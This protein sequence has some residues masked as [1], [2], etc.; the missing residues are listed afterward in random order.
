MG[1]RTTKSKIKA[2]SNKAKTFDPINATANISYTA[3]FY[4]TFR[5][6]LII[7]IPLVIIS[8]IILSSLHISATD[9]TSSTDTLSFNIS[10]SCTLSSV[11]DSSHT[12][13]LIN[14]TYTNSIGQTTITTLCND[15]NGYSVY[16]VGYS[17]NE[18]G[19]N[20]LVNTENSNFNIISGTAQSGTTSNWAMSLNHLVDDPSFTPPVIT[21]GYDGIYGIVPNEWTKVAS[22]PARATDMIKGS[23]F[24]TTYAVYTS[25]SQYAGT[26]NGQV[27]YMLVHP[28]YKPAVYFMQDVASW[29]NLIDTDESVQAIDQRD[30]K[31]YWVTKLQDGNIWMTSNL[32]LDIGGLNTTALN[33]NNTDIST[34]PNVYAGSGIYSDYNVSDGVYTWNPVSTAKTSS[35]YI[36]NTTVKPSA[37]PTNNTGHT[38]P[39]SLEG[40][41]TYYYTSNTTGNDTRYNSLQACKDASHT[42]DECKRYF[43]GNYYNWSA[44]IASNNSTNIGGTVGEIASNSICPKGWRLPN[45]SQTDNINNEFGR[46]LYQAEI[47]A[48]VSAGNDSVGYATG[49]FNKLRSNPYYF[50]RSGFILGGTL[51]NPGVNGY[52]WS[53]TVSSGTYAYSLRFG[54]TDI[55]PARSIDRYYGWFVRCVAR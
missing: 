1:Y 34:D 37:W 31:S 47:T 5:N 54:G 39:Y 20:K 26:Y 22:L 19:N 4:H 49:G 14:G 35:Y 23:S 52:Y 53:S 40:G 50:V 6:V 3:F 10:S 24:T 28:S 17:N 11:V 7:S 18:E 8:A 27:K 42:E 46:M 9:S 51:Y 36:D 12:A 32:D 44:A 13:E 15:G 16:A 48:K 2:G 55:Y 25:S 43:V 29:K 21:S 30:G 45:A 33:S 38:T 41:D